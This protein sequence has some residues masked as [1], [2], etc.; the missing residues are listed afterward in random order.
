MTSNLGS[1]YFQEGFYGKEEIERKIMDL[2]KSSLR[3]EFLNRIDEVIIFNNLTMDHILQIVDIQ[4]KY[5]NSR[6][7]EK[8]LF[9]EITERAK[10]KI[11]EIGYDPIFGARPLKR[12]IQRYIENPL[13]IK[14]L[15]GAFT[16]GDVVVVDVNETGEFEF[17][18]KVKH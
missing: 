12:A 9:L 16:E 2:L 6:L 11:A 4:I 8:G 5:L 15:E 13:A 14:V 18:K 7:A 10:L 1:H 3:P 17:H